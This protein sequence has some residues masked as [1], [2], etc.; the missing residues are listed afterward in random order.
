MQKAYYSLY[1]IVSKF[2]GI[3]EIVKE[4]ELTESERDKI[5]KAIESAIEEFKEQKS[6]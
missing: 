1:Q 5:V 6:G 3:I 2:E 4:S